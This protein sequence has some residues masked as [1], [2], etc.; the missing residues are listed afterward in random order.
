MLEDPA[1]IFVGDVLTKVITTTQ[2]AH[3]VRTGSTAT[4]R[5]P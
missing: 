3:A 5:N 4:R 1:Q 2:P